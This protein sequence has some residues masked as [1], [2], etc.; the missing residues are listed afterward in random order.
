[1]DNCTSRQQTRKCK[2]VPSVSTDS[3]FED[4]QESTTQS[5]QSSHKMMCLGLGEVF[6]VW[7]SQLMWVWTLTLR[8]K[9]TIRMETQPGQQV[10]TDRL[11]HNTI[12]SE[13]WLLINVP[14]LSSPLLSSPLLS[15]PLLSSPLLS[16]PLLSS[17]LLSSPLLSLQ[18]KTTL[19][20]CSVYVV[21]WLLYPAVSHWQV[22][23]PVSIWS[24][25]AQSQVLPCLPARGRQIPT[26][27]TLSVS[28]V[29]SSKKHHNCP[30]NIL[31]RSQWAETMY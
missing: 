10:K 19:P 13:Y 12:M 6:T 20:L 24:T 26:N 8:R 7:T 25:S 14:L 18:L 23:S 17:P 2:A 16:S 15:S 3:E 29:L 9:T 21:L 4:P 28:A 1:M 11:T 31:Q 27:K 22:S 30:T 5:S